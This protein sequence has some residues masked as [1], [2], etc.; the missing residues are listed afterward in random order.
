MR[1]GK[2]KREKERERDRFA[3]A[4]S[5]AGHAREVGRS[6]KMSAEGEEP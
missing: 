1:A 6:N 3:D 5:P 2:A 4:I